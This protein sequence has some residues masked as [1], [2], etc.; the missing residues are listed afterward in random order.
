[1]IACHKCNRTIEDGEER[2]LYSEVLCDDCYIERIWHRVRK[3]Y[4]ENDPA[5]FMRRLQESYS[6]QPQRYH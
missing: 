1:M 4:Y 6:V 5:S 3:V 2:E